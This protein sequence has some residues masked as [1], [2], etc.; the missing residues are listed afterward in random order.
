MI[1]SFP[2]L[3]FSML[4]FAVLVLTGCAP[5][6]NSSSGSAPTSSGHVFLIMMENRS[7]DQAL[8]GSYTASLASEY[9]VATDYHAVTHPSLPNYLAL[10]SGSTWDI[11]NDKY[12]ALPSGEDVGSELTSAGIPWKAYMEDMSNG[13]FDS[14]KPYALNHNP[15]AFYGGQCPSNVVDLSQLDA[16]LSGE[17]PNFAWI[18]PNL[19]HQ[20]HDCS[21]SS[22][23]QW[24]AEVVP[25]ITESDA[26]KQDGVLFI[27]WDE[28]EKKSA[29][30]NRVA[31][32]VLAPDLEEHQTD[33]YYDHY[34]LLATIED[35]LGVERLGEAENTQAI[36][37]LF[38][39]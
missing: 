31:L 9:A 4:S 38:Q 35:R 24:L 20:G 33:A 39:T 23:D 10:T 8:G 12:Q 1:L 5:A 36:E 22:G 3:S 30:E 29:S 11:T 34:S 28:D 16:D 13:C 6:S 27:V 2:I 7:Y 17:T 14:P 32:I 37:D 25:K 26:W 18:T 21:V 19:C 15:F